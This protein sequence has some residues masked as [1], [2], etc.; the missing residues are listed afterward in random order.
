MQYHI[1]IFILLTLYIRKCNATYF[2]I[3]D[4]QIILIIISSTLLDIKSIYQS[5]SPVN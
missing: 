5:S 2:D 3:S 4:I 1:F